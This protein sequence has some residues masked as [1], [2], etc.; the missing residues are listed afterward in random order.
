MKSFVSHVRIIVDVLSAALLFASR[1]EEH[2]VNIETSRAVSTSL[3][4]A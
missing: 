1:S 2:Q 3:S 4:Q